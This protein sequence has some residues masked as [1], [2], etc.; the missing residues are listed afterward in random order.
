MDQKLP[1]RRTARSLPIA[2]LRA[3]E[4]VMAPIRIMLNQSGISEQ[5]WRVIR[6]LDESGPMEQ[7]TLAQAACLLLPSLTRMLRA[8]EDEGLLTRRT[9]PDDGR[10]SIV[11][12]TTTGR[13]MLQNHAVEAAALFADLE[14]RFGA[15]R[16][17]HLLDLLEELN[18]LKD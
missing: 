13:E 16:M 9:D 4:T 11:S 8:M 3:R 14:K 6:V 1:L 10:K 2:L 15:E 12:V 18:N 17:E 5:K 7:T